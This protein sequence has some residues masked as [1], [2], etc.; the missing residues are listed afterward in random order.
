M[1]DLKRSRINQFARVTL[2]LCL[3][4]FICVTLF[5]GYDK[6]NERA[7]QYET[8]LGRY[9]MTLEQMSVRLDGDFRDLW[10]IVSIVEKQERLRPVYIEVGNIPN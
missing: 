2:S 1:N 7:K 4:A 3:V 10:Q 5:Y 6:Y 9:E 8:K